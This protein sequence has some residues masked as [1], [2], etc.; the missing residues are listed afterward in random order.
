MSLSTF[1]I[2]FKKTLPLL[3][4]AGVLAACATPAPTSTP[5][6]P[7][8][9]Q[10]TA[11]SVLIKGKSAR[12]ILDKVVDYRT[13]RGMTVIARDSSRVTLVLAVPNSKPPAEASMIFSISPETHGI[14]LSAQVFQTVRHPEKTQTTDIT[15]T[16]ISDLNSELRMYARE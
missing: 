13:K 15:H 11:P 1:P 2:R 5:D 4:A 9:V 12:Q 16:L 14:R 10:E 7:I 3:I 8:V 6:K